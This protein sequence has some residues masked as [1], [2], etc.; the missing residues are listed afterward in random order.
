VIVIVDYQ[1]G[2]V[3]S[4]ANMLR[5]L[6]AACMISSAKDVI[7]SADKLILP[8]VGAFDTG[9][10]H[11]DAL[12]LVEVLNEKVVTHHTPVLGI[13]LG[14]QLLTKRSEEGCLQGLDWVDG[15]TVRFEFDAPL[16][17][18]KVPHMGWNTVRP[19]P[20][21]RL[22]REE[23]T[24]PRFYFVHSYYVRCAQADDVAGWAHYGID[25]A[26]VVEHKNILGTQFHPEKSHRHG[27]SLLRNFMEL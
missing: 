21:A 11:L 23:D 14:M 7:A 12:D 19:T 13:C 16:K 17:H 10:E 9:M 15:E 6:G 22:F 1:M 2:N 27:M 4:V 3:G 8:G 26:A 20:R 24:E 18:L 25:F 5:K